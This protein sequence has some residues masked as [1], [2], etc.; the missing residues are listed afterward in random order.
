MRG[1]GEIKLGMDYGDVKISSYGNVEYN[2]KSKKSTFNISM[3]IDMP[4]DKNVMESFANKIKLV[5]QYR[6]MDLEEI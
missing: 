5:D 1:E 4:I 2:E 3:R 6:P